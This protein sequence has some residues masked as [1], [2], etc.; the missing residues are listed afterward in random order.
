MYVEATFGSNL[1][2]RDSSEM[3]F[4]S[5]FFGNHAGIELIS[6]SILAG[7]FVTEPSKPFSD[8]GL[9]GIEF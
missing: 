7:F 4:Q 9:A 1:A 5:G 2:R 6:S 8:V 3:C